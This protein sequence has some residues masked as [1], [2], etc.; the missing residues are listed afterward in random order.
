MTPWVSDGPKDVLGYVREYLSVWYLV[1]TDLA[2]PHMTATELVGAIKAT[3]RL[4][5]VAQG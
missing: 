3:D 4:E 5:C 2:M 1:I